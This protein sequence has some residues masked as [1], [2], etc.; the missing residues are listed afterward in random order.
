MTG[1][2]E[3]KQPLSFTVESTHNRR[4][5]GKSHKCWA[6]FTLYPSDINS[7]QQVVAGA[8]RTRHNPAS[9]RLHRSSVSRFG[10]A[11][12]RGA[13]SYG[14]TFFWKRST[15]GGDRCEAAERTIHV[16]AHQRDQE[17]DTQFTDRNNVTVFSVL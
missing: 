4:I 8:L 14:Q 5:R 7:E 3:R 11:A 15:D 12:A 16:H 10:N 9:Q 2:P 1:D 13:A 17:S 6:G